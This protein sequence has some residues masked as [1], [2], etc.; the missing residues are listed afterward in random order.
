MKRSLVIL[1]TVAWVGTAQAVDKVKLDERVRTLAA[2]FQS[3]QSQ[4]DKR[5]PADV[6]RKAQAVV[7]LDRTKAGFLFAFQGGGGVALVRDPGTHRWSPAAF[8]AANEASLGFQIGG[9]QNFFV[10]LLMDTNATRL[11]TEASFDFAGEAR[12]TAG[13]VS[14]G[15]ESSVNQPGPPVLV[16]GER[17]GLYGGAAVKAGAIAPDNEANRAYYGQFVTMRDILFDRKVEATPS[18]K[19]LAA[20]ITE[21]ANRAKP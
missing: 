12:G 13:D 1:T 15:V 8:V 19:D 10:I 3:L 7:L 6:L 11:L 5:I 16:Y 9:E 20:T 21:Y 18:S 4:P 2:K 14:S 17:E